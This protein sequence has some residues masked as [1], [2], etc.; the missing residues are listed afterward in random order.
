M[1]SIMNTVFSAPARR[2]A[3]VLTATFAALLPAHAMTMARQNPPAKTAEVPAGDSVPTNP[4]NPFAGKVFVSEAHIDR[5]FANFRFLA[6]NTDESATEGRQSLRLEDWDGLRDRLEK[7]IQYK[8]DAR[9][10]ILTLGSA[11]YSYEFKNSKTVELRQAL[12]TAFYYEVPTTPAVFFRTADFLDSQ[13][14][15]SDHDS[16]NRLMNMRLGMLNRY[17]EAA[18]AGN[19]P[20]PPRPGPVSVNSSPAGP[21]PIPSRTPTPNPIAG[22]YRGTFLNEAEGTSRQFELR[23]GSL[24][25]VSGAPPS[26][27]IMGSVRFVEDGKGDAGLQGIVTYGMETTFTLSSSDPSGTMT[28]DGRLDGNKL[29][30]A[31][32]VRDLSGTTE[33]RGS[34]EANRGQ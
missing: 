20:P 23:L 27:G 26:S 8:V 31:W 18:K 13:G 12:N 24:G 11:G 33:R 1:V 5:F 21:N 19:A 7:Q 14:S 10:R 9:K 29:S 32:R 28:F 17:I 6:F 2:I 4:E 15:L 25:E 30:G 34:F 22:L 3:F 16:K